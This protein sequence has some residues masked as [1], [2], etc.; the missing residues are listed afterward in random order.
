MKYA[1]PLAAALY[2]ALCGPWALAADPPKL[3]A[4]QFKE[5]KAATD[6]V[7]FAE[8]NRHRAQE[9][10]DKRMTAYRAEE[11]KVAQEAQ[12]VANKLVRAACELKPQDPVPQDALTLDGAVKCP[13]KAE[14]KK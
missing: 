6:K 9:E 2:L 3:T 11:S 7:L 10:H 13:P 1:L 8:L 12:A 4:E 14:P 5:W